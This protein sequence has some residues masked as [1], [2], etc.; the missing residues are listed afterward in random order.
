MC[1]NLTML[2]DFYQLTMLY[3]Y[4]KE[5]TYEKQVVFDLFFRKNSGTSAYAIFAGLEQMIDYVNQLHFSQDDI[6]YL[7]S[8]HLF[9]EDFFEWLSDFH[10]TGEIYAMPE[11]SVVFPNEPLVRVCAPLGEAQLLETAVLNIINFQTLIATKAS[12]VVHAAGNGSVLEFGL[13]RAQGPYAGIYGARAAVIG[14]CVATSDVLAGQLFDIPIRGTH[15]HSWVMSFPD[16]LSAFRAYARNFPDTCLLLVDTYDTLKSG[17]P[18]AI[19]VFQELRENGHEG[20][21]IRL[22]S[23]DLAYLSKKARIMLDEAGFEDVSIFASNDL[24][25]TLIRDL[26]LQGARIDTWGVGTQLITGGKTPALGGV[27]KLSAEF[28]GGKMQPRMKLSD[29]REK[30]SNPGVKKVVRF[31]E[32]NSGKAMAD[33]IA[34]ED[35]HF[36]G[37]E[38]LRIY[39]PDSPWMSKVIEN[40]Y[41]KDLLVSIFEKGQCVYLKKSVMELQE[42]AAQE[43]DTLWEE[44]KRDL[45]PSV[46]KVDL[47]DH[48]YD[49][50]NALIAE[51][52]HAREN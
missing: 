40:Y 36:E 4:F 20:V 30:T 23:G 13:R 29:T 32:K 2:T 42:Y 9:D 34:L 44:Y 50:K 52:S 10:F 27:Y 49:L 51:L 5:K 15:A 25:E 43:L 33:L 39:H 3:G 19:K 37:G 47:S 1:R 45:N 35:E 31:Y 6:S 38:P 41:T 16:E 11:G 46:Y 18:N 28:D 22:D 17:V 24:D 26:R 12:R 48:V 21:G 7:R 8:L 14:G